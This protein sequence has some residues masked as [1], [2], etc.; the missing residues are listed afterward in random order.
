MYK[1]N[2]RDNQNKDFKKKKRARKDDMF[3]YGTALGVK[4]V[5]GNL[6]AALRLLKRTVKDSGMMDILRDKKE[7][8]KPT[9]LRRKQREDAQRK[10]YIRRINEG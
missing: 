3:M 4:V 6:E 1:K 2:N 5:D 10:E 8:T 9:T 7:Y